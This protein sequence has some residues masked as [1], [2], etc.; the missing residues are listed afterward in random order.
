MVSAQID[1]LTTDD[2]KIG[3]VLSGGGAKAIAQIGALKVIE[4]A[5]IELDYIAGTSMGAIIG[6]MYS[7]GYSAEQIEDY[8][9]R[10]D[11]DALLANEVPRNRLGYFDRKYGNRYILNL[12]VEN[13]KVKLPRGINYAQYILREL[14]FIT[15]QSYRY[16]N[17]RDFP[18]PFLCV[19]TNL[20]TGTATTFENGRLMDALRA[21]SAFPSLFTPYEIND[22]LYIDGG[23][24]NNYPAK[25]LKNRGVDLIIGVDVQKD[26]LELREF[27]SVVEV[28]EQ[29]STFSNSKI[30]Q[31]QYALTDLLIKP[32]MDQAGITTFNLYDTLIKAGEYA[33]RRNW[34]ALLNIAQKDSSRRPITKAENAMPLPEFKVSSICVFGN[35]NYTDEYIL[36]KLR[37]KP[38]TTCNIQQLERGLDLL[39]GS[40]YFENVDYTINRE[41]DGYRLNINLKENK[42]LSTFKIGLNYND[43]FNTALLLNFTQRNLLFKNSRFSVD[44]ALGDNPRTSINYFVDRGFVPTL[45]FQFRS[46]RFNFRDYENF[47]AT[48]QGIYQDFSLDLFLQST[49]LD[50]YALG[51]GLQI[52][53]VDINSTFDLGNITEMN[54]SYIN[55]YGFIDFDSFDDAYF[56]KRGFQLQAQ[57]RLIAEREGFEVFRQPSSIIN[58]EFNKAVSLGKSVSLIGRFYGASTLGPDLDFPYK[59]HLGS[60]G[61]KYINNIQPFIGYR[62]ME[63]TGR[64]ALT[65]RGDVFYQFL[66]NHY[67]VGR[68]NLGKLEPTFDDLFVSR[69]LVDGYSLGYCF[70]SP[71][72]PLELNVIGSSN[73]SK[74]YTYVNLGFW[75]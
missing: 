50:A 63:I 37:I 14:S 31:E 35:E 1:T 16:N 69:I 54:R 5:G 73:H 52:E 3:L 70:N 56:P 33:A 48:N 36:S 32:I 20:Q 65:A 11:W 71:V 44:L 24:V 66:K 6:A 30:Q 53:N 2:Y 29:T 34:K 67:L 47:K 74:V 4:Q 58:L 28:L 64:N 7:L 21:S 75:F 12:P 40:Q 62:F 38:G 45:G 60:L 43:D 19:A 13:G 15:Q 41:G 55:Y 42:V 72:G 9:R 61:R 57:Y 68:Y 49:I 8:L 27:N 59:I 46:N 22:T 17:F 18:I 10:V 25:E 39:Y 51:G 23:V 26:N